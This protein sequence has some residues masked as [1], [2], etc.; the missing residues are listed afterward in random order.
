MLW[1]ATTSTLPKIDNCSSVIGPR[2]KMSILPLR[3]ATMV[4]SIP[5]SVAPPSTI[6]GMRSSSSSRTCCAV[7][8]LTRPK[9]FALGAASGL[10]KSRIISAKTGWALI[11]TA[12]VSKPA[13]T[14]SGTIGW[15]GKTIVKGPGQSRSA[16]VKTNCRSCVERSTTRSNQDLSGRWTMS[17]SK[18]GRSL[19][20][21]ILATASGLSASA[22]RP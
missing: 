14:I 13:V 3:T 18:R 1:A 6:S 7:V 19:A 22:A 8:G 21:K 16:S 9:R 2:R 11:R 4:D 17:G 10:P 20:S 5:C 15:R 12:T